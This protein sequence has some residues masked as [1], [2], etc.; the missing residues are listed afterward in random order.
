M[1]N[2]TIETTNALL[3][4]VNETAQGSNLDLINLLDSPGSPLGGKLRLEDEVNPSVLR[5][6]DLD[7]KSYKIDE[8]KITSNELSYVKLNSLSE[9]MR[10]EILQTQLGKLNNHS[11]SSVKINFPLSEIKCHVGSNDSTCSS[12]IKLSQDIMNITLDKLTFRVSGESNI[13][14]NMVF[15]LKDS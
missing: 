4:S 14:G 13:D 7:Q 3:S 6:D 10:K 8:I 5:V 1:T 9:Y 12:C 15:S 11:P 2:A